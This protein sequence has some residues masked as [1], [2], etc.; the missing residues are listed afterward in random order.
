MRPWSQSWRRWWLWPSRPTWRTQYRAPRTR[1]GFTTPRRLS[2]RQAAPAMLRAWTTTCDLGAGSGHCDTGW[3]G[4]RATGRGGRGQPGHRLPHRT[5]ADR[6]GLRT[7]APSPGSGARR[8]TAHRAPV[9]GGELDRLMDEGHAA[10]VGAVVAR[11]NSLGWETRPEVSFSVYGESGIDRCGRLA[12]RE[13]HPPRDRGEDG[14]RVDRGDAPSPRCQGSAGR[15]G[16]RGAVRLEGPAGGSAPGAPG[17][18]DGARPGTPERC[19]APGGAASCGVRRC[20]PGCGR[21]PAPSRASPS[22]RSRV[23][24][25]VVGRPSSGSGSGGG[26]RRLM[27]LRDHHGAHRTGAARARRSAHQHLHVARCWRV[28]SAHLAFTRGEHAC[29]AY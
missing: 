19:R 11:L 3:V 5:R 17:R 7:G 6:R 28:G 23:A 26:R 24:S 12:R 13:R 27:G 16:R 29:S 20:G 14:A 9:P 10:L 21:R 8:G 18:V 2:G 25:V 22:Y 4:A 1:R 15:R